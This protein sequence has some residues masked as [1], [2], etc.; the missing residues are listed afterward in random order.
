MFI[1]FFRENI[2][3]HFKQIV[4][5]GDNLLGMS[6]PSFWENS[7]KKKKKKKKKNSNFWNDEILPSMQSINQH[8][9][10]YPKYL[11]TFLFYHI[12]PKILASPT[13]NP[14]LKTVQWHPNQSALSGAVWYRSTVFV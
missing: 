9:L 11:D 3:W 6:T 1:L 13:E 5:K 4:S 2:I 12:H 7:K 14:V 8:V 10:Y